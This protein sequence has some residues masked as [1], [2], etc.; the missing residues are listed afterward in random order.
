MKQ[1]IAIITSVMALGWHA[2]AISYEAGS[3]GLTAPAGVS[4]TATGGNLA[5][6]TVAGVVGLGV[7]GGASGGE[8]DLGQSLTVSFT[9]APQYVGAL[10]LAFLYNGPEFGDRREIAAVNVGGTEYRLQAITATTA[11]WTGFGGD[12]SV[13]NLRPASLGSAAV[14][15]IQNPFGDMMVSSFDLYPLSSN[16]QGNESDFSLQAFRTKD[17]PRG[18]PDAGSTIALLG[19]TVGGL[20][21]AKRRLR[22]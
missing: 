2:S 8:I 17:G 6:K 14:W 21:G 11:T 15:R 7:S 1:A 19:L 4:F 10:T 16:P 12:S 22:V 18:V 3:D 20:V 5:L 9:S 13:V